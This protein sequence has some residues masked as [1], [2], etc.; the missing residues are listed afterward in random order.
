MPTTSPVPF[1][2]SSTTSR[3]SAKTLATTVRVIQW[4]V[5]KTIAGAPNGLTCAE[6]E[7]KLPALRQS[8]VSARVRDLK[9][10]S[11]VVPVGTRLTPRGR[12][13]DVL[14]VT[15]KGRKLVQEAK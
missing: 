8:T 5:L 1:V 11:L 13:A 3:A 15:G 2:R 4:R 6:I 10:L 9:S 14:V 12:E 7:H